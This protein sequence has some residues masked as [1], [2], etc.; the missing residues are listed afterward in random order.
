[1]KALLYALGA[2][3]K[4]MCQVSFSTWE[5][6]LGCKRSLFL[7]DMQPVC[8]GGISFQVATKVNKPEK[9]TLQTFANTFPT[10]QSTGPL[11]K[12]SSLTGSACVSKPGISRQPPSTAKLL[13]WSLAR[14]AQASDCFSRQ[15]LQV[16]GC[17]Q[18]PIGYDLSAKSTRKN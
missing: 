2:E 17:S 10:S 13:C 9:I 4:F 12:S 8:P 15:Q 3:N 11:S 1:M 14:L 16:T 7:W 6:Y 18:G 5:C